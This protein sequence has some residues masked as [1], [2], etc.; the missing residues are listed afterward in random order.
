MTYKIAVLPWDGIWPEVCVE[1]L[2]VLE[3]V[4][5]KYNF[6]YETK[7]ALI[8]WAAWPKYKNHFPQDAK[9]VCDWSEAILY[10]SVGWPVDKQFEPQWLDAEKNAVLGVRKYLWLNVNIRPSRVWPKL[11]HLSVLK[12]EKIPEG[13]LEIVT[14]RELSGGLYFGK[15]S[16]YI[17][18]WERKAQ[19]ICDYD[20]STIRHIAE[21][22]FKAASRSGKK[23]ALVD[24]ANVLDTSRLW[25]TVVEEVSE[26]YPEVELEKW[27]VDNCAMQLVKNP[28]WFEYILTENLFG[29]ILSDLTSTFGGSMWL[30]AS[31]SFN[32][33]G[34][35]MYEPSGWS[36]PKYTGLN[37]INPIAQILCVAMMMRHSFKREDVA[38]SI[39]GA[40]NKTIDD[41]YRTYDIYR[42]LDW[43]KLVGTKEMGDTILQHLK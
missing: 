33:E 5:K 2:K 16:T 35:W 41:W 12:E 39:E 18:N 27:L 4:S 22:C 23:I 14:F 29:D 17:E 26:D 28:D 38:L 10:G 32:I 8:G 31:A 21:F 7:H 34:F 9:D 11:A 42:E 19:D 13:W 40:V 24:K 15:H 3:A 6:E 1:A 20:E 37:K 30:L 43:E 25:R 36:A